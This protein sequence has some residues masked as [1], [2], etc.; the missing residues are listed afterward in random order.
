LYHFIAEVKFAA[1]LH[2]NGVIQNLLNF[3]YE[4]KRTVTRKTRIPVHPFYSRP[5]SLK[6]NP[7][8]ALDWKKQ[9]CKECWWNDIWGKTPGDFLIDN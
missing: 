6:E 7:V 9:H 4:I 8:R 3:G 1:S 2:E 5:I